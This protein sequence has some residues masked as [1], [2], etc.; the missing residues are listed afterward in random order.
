MGQNSF[1]IEF[2]GSKQ[3][4]CSLRK[5]DNNPLL[6]ICNI[7]SIQSIIYLKE[8]QNEI[9]LNEK[10]IYTNKRIIKCIVPESH[11]KGKFSRYYYTIL[12]NNNLKTQN[13]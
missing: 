7:N 5:Y 4:I 12:I 2:L 10:N 8:I 1:E 6:L 11:F 13:I 9:I 3:V